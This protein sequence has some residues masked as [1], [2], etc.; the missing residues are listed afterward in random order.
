MPFTMNWNRYS[1]VI[2]TTYMIYDVSLTSTMV[3]IPHILRGT[4]W[5]WAC[6]FPLSQTGVIKGHRSRQRPMPSRRNSLSWYLFWGRTYTKS[7]MTQILW[8]CGWIFINNSTG[9]LP[10]NTITTWLRS[11]KGYLKNTRTGFCH[12]QKKHRANVELGFITKM[13]HAPSQ[14]SNL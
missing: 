6:W 9:W 8:A 5:H 12:T 1:L 7:V 11:L 10:Q 13:G 2:Y 4:H 14:N 3:Q